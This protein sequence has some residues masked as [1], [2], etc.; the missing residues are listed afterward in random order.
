MDVVSEFFDQAHMRVLD[1]EIYLKRRALTEAEKL[2]E[3]FNPKEFVLAHLNHREWVVD[4]VEGRIWIGN[5]Q[6]EPV[7]VELSVKAQDT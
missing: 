1:K 7:E 4:N 5:D 6:G 3:A 2:A